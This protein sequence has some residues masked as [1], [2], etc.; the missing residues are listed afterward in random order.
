M[1]SARVRVHRVT[2]ERNMR[3]TR[4]TTRIRCSISF[5][6]VAICPGNQL[7]LGDDILEK[8]SKLKMKKEIFDH[9]KTEIFMWSNFQHRIFPKSKEK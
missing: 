8:Q 5:S 9:L 1:C 3:D 6:A 4:S 7:T 2:K